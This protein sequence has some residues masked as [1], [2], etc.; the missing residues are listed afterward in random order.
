MPRRI[1]AGS[2]TLRPA[3]AARGPEA[4]V[5]AK[6]NASERGIR[7][8]DGTE[9]VEKGRGA[10]SRSSVISGPG[11]GCAVET[12]S[13]RPYRKVRSQETAACEPDRTLAYRRASLSGRA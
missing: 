10:F 8:D 9:N 13:A 2:G 1:R 11:R 7:A 3:I 4:T 12:V 5:E 6:S